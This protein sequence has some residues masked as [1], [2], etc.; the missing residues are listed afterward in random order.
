MRVDWVGAR[1][2]HSS[3][4][5]TGVKTPQGEATKVHLDHEKGADPQVA[6]KVL[7]DLEAKHRPPA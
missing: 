3:L 5:L 1:G 7:A 4:L 6:L 2:L